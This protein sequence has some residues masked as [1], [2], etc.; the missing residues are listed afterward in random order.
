VSWCEYVCVADKKTDAHAHTHTRTHPHNATHKPARPHM[1]TITQSH[2]QHTH[3]RTHAIH[4]AH[5]CT[6]N[7][8]KAYTAHKHTHKHTG[9][10]IHTRVPMDAQ[11]DYCFYDEFPARTAALFPD[12]TH[13]AKYVSQPA[14]LT[15][16]QLQLQVKIVIVM[17]NH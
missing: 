8:E 1:R 11:K 15:E 6:H 12:L 10:H 16:Q 13:Y 4:A 17:V 9:A 5:M 3:A 2:T 14:Q 7:T